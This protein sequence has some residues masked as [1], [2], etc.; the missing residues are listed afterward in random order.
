LV[1][2]LVT[3]EVRRRLEFATKLSPDGGKSTAAVSIEVIKETE[4][5][6]FLSPDDAVSLSLQYFKR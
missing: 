2:G 5:F 6:V 3:T 1:P 4:E